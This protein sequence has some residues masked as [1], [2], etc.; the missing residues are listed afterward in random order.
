MTRNAAKRLRLYHKEYKVSLIE[1]NLLP[2]LY[3]REVLDI[4]FYLKSY[5]GKTGYNV[6]QD[7]KFVDEGVERVTRNVA[8]VNTLIRQ[9]VLVQFLWHP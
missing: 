4:T 3:R 6:R 1:C 9:E 2:L 5:H 8:R 7:M